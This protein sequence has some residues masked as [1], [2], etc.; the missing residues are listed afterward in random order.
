MNFLRKLFRGFDPWLMAGA[1]VLVS[2]GLLALSSASVSRGSREIVVQAA[3]AG[4]GLIVMLVVA[5][6]HPQTIYRLRYW[7][8]LSTVAAL[9]AVLLLGRT[10]N[11]TRGWF[12]LGPVTFQPV[13]YA[14]FALVIILAAILP[15]HARLQSLRAMIGAS[16]V[17]A[18]L[19]VLVLLQPDLGSA[20]IL[21]ALWSS[22]LLVSGVPRR[23]IVLMFL[24]AIAVVALAWAFALQPYQHDRVLTFLNP[25][26]D[27]RG[28]GYNVTQAQ[29]AVGSGGLWGAGFASGSQSQLRFLPESQ[30]DFIFSFISE[31][32]GLVAS[33]LLL[34]AFAVIIWRLS[35]LATRAP[36]DF[37][38]FVAVGAAALISVEAFVAVGGNIGLVPVTGITLPLV[39]AGGSSLVA[40]LALLGLAQSVSRT[41]ART[42]AARADG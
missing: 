40:H 19:V 1:G 22:M 30:T 28:Q 23:Q 37:T 13:E 20:L 39:S 17:T 36:D 25:A 41:A 8:L 35:R 4:I 26:R 7:I 15:M 9:V 27:P 34:A 6:A 16:A 29:I 18:V 10:V 5:N 42:T 12:V 31:E 14:K 38:Q 24:S 21:V 11:G 32:F 2:L 3:A 33:T